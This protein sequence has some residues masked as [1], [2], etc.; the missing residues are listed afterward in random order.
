MTYK[1]QAYN[2]SGALV[3]GVLEVSSETQAEEALSRSELT[4]VQLKRVQKPIGLED[5]FPSLF[6]VKQDD[7]IYFSRQL[8]TLLDAGV[9]LLRALEGMEKQTTKKAFRRVLVAIRSDLQ[10]GM[11]FSEAVSRQ[12][13]VFPEVFMRLISIAEQTGSL[14]SML[15]EISDHLEK[16]QELKRKVTGALIYPGAVMTMASMAIFVIIKFVVPAMTE[17]FK[18]FNT[19]LPIYTRIMTGG[20]AFIANNFGAILVTI[21]ATVAATALYVRS[22]EGAYRK[23]A[24]LLKVPVVGQLITQSNTYSMA[25]NF[26]ILLK[27]GVSFT[28]S[29]EMLINTMGNR[30]FKRALEDMRTDI[31]EGRGI[32]EA[33]AARNVFPAPA[34]QLIEVGEQT[35]SIE[36]SME[37]ISEIYEE[38]TSRAVKALTGTIAPIMTIVMGLVVA[39]IALSVV[40]PI[41]SA[42][43]ALR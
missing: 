34:I 23:D 33:M 12:K 30:V 26:K 25:R 6:G 29:L 40:T 27:S 4:V 19:Q 35:G 22:K 10:T 20:A 2:K 39:F 42:V 13:K 1:Y 14:A 16:Q 11:L 3:E 31:L 24:F 37:L 17:L 43:R 21:I 8:A 41:Y 36:S 32:S 15:G 5:F 7:I 18:E 28:E 38:E 9:S